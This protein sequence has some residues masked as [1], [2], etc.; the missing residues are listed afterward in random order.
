MTLRT[1]RI[2]GPSFRCA[3][4][5]EYSSSTRTLVAPRALDTYTP[6]ARPQTNP[7]SGVEL[8][9]VLDTSQD[10]WIIGREL[11]NRLKRLGLTQHVSE[12][13]RIMDV[14]GDSRISFDE[15]VRGYEKVWAT[16]VRAKAYAAIFIAGL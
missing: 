11:R 4:P 9:Q 1:S 2:S 7:D 14:D 8:G 15:F 16:K 13:L 3:D 5:S 10:G 6:P 12:I